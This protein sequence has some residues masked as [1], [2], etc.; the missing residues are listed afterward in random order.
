MSI[1]KSKKLYLVAYNIRSLYNVGSMLRTADAFGVD[2]VYLAGYTGYPPREKI[3]KTALGAEE[4]V[5]WERHW[6][7]IEL[8]KELKK[9]KI[10]IVS[11]EVT[12]KSKPLNNFKPKFPVAL[13][14]GNEKNGI[15]KKV[16]DLSDHVVHI[17]MQGIKESLNV[18]VA[19]GVALNLLN[20]SR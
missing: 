1:N 17:P 10:Q 20:L 4:V 16:L 5:P 15:S 12:K 9:Q 3:S 7:G 8:I 18:S 13:I 14:V 2:K 19:T 6:R 11:L